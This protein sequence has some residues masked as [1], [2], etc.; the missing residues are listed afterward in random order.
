[1]VPTGAGREQATTAPSA[2]VADRPAGLG[3]GT[4][5]T[6]NSVPATLLVVHGLAS[7]GSD[8]PRH[9]TLGAARDDEICFRVSQT[10]SWVIRERWQP[11]RTASTL[12]R[13]GVGLPAAL[14]EA[15]AEPQ[16]QR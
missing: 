15:G 11:Q 6:A 14:D 4:S 12:R 16:H 5:S 7:A 1:M 2:M 9:E 8:A 10:R 3:R 13:F